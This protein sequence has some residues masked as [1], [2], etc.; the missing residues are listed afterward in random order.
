[1]G[2]R[3]LLIDN[4]DSFT[5]NLVHLLEELD[6]LVFTYRNDEVDIETLWKIGPTHILISPGPGSPRSAGVSR[7]VV[8]KTAGK[9]PILGVCLGH[10]VIAD[11]FGARV[12]RGLEPVHGK[13]SYVHHDSKTIF[14]GI[15][16]PIE[17]M[18][19]HSLV[20]E[21]SGIPPSLEVSS[22]TSDGVVMSIRHRSFQIEGVQFH[23]ESILTSSGKRIVSNFLKMARGAGINYE[24]TNA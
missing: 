22:T 20:V 23:P 14:E 1:M 24:N 2:P 18:R 15:E 4:Y 11:A 8:L 5:Y 12:V 17:V 10:Q 13:T 9:I 3:I 19:Y 7:D 6:C 16:S 21:P